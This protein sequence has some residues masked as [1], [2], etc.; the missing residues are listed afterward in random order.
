MSTVL[1]FLFFYESMRLMDHR[2]S[3]T[4]HAMLTSELL[5]L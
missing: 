5:Q 1:A 2:L 4:L 3:Q